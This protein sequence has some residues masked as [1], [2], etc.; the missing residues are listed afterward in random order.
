MANRLRGLDIKGNQLFSRV[1]PNIRSVDELQKVVDA[2]TRI[3]TERGV[4]FGS[5]EI[6]PETGKCSLSKVH[7]HRK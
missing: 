3:G 5:K 4:R 2:V 1:S 7:S 6:N